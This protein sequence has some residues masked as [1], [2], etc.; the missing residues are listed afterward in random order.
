M[1]SLRTDTIYVVAAYTSQT[2][3]LCGHVDRNSRVT[4]RKFVC[5]GCGYEEHADL[6]VAAN[7]LRA[8][9]HGASGCAR[10]DPIR[11][12]DDPSSVR[13]PVPS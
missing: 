6:N 2:C 4:L 5:L 10:G 1:K 3:S 7:T 12:P 9:G 13:I 8:P 11:D